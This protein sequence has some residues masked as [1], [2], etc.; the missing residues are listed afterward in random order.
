MAL[1]HQVM[2]LRQTFTG[3]DDGESQKGAEKEAGHAGKCDIHP[4][5]APVRA[6]QIRSDS[7]GRPDQK[8]GQNGDLT[9][10]YGCRNLAKS[11]HHRRTLSGSTADR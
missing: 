4:D 3:P 2:N 9:V 1:R 8:S 7:H 11:P 5:V 6:Y 10:E